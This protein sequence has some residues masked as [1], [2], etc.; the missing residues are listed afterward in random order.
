MKSSLPQ[1]NKPSPVRVQANSP[2]PL[3]PHSIQGRVFNVLTDEPAN[4]E[5]ILKLVNSPGKLKVDYGQIEVALRDLWKK[6]FV[7]KRTATFWR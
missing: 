4:V 5:T 3:R 6:G 2:T 1:A 7:K